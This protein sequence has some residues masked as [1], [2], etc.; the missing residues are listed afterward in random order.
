MQTR[1]SENTAG[2]QPELALR[3][4]MRRLRE[5]FAETGD[6][7]SRLDKVVRHV[8]GVMVAEVC[9]IYLKRQDGSLELFATEGL[10]PAS[11]HT[12]RLKRGEG[13]VGRC[14]ELGVPINE[15]DAQSHPAFSLRPETG[16]EVYH[17]LLAVPILRSGQVLGVLVVQ[18]HAYK[19]YSDDD[20][21]TL[22]STAM[23]VGEH[24]ATG[25]VARWGSDIEISRSLAAVVKGEPLSDGI[26]LGHVLLHEPRIV[27]TKLM[28]DDPAIELSRL[29]A[30]IAELRAAL[31]EMLGQEQLASD[32]D[33][34]DVL[35]AYRMFAHDRGWERRLREAV[36]SGLTAEAA[37]E[38]VQNS[39]RARMTRHAD[40]YWAERQR[41]F[42]DLS[43]RLQRILSG[44]GGNGRDVP[45]EMPSDTILVARTMGP[46]EL[47][48]YD[49]ARLRGL[50]IEDSSPQSHVAIV[51]KAL[52][53]PAVGRAV[54]IVDHVSPGD[55]IIIDAETG[56]VHLRPLQDVVSA[57]S[58]KV[59]FRARRQKKYGALRDKK[60]ITRDG[61]RIEVNINAGLL[62]DLSH[63][64]ESGADGIGLFR[65]ELQFMV[66]HTFPR[67]ERQAE[68]YRQVVEA[69]AGRP[70]VFRALDI[71]GDKVLPYLRSVKEEN[72]A[73]GWR[74]IRM[75]LDRPALFRTQVR[76]LLK[77][78][79]GGELRLMVP[80]IS[81][82]A[83][84]VTVK[85][86]FDRELGLIRRK[87]LPSP[88][89][90]KLGAMFE[91]PSLLFELDALL[92]SVDFLSI[93]SN[94]LLQFMFAAD[95]TN[96]RVASRYD[97]LSVAP[98]RALKSVADACRGHG[99]PLTICGEMAG[100]P[101]EAM[102]LIA[103]GFRSVSMAPSSVGPI[104]AMILSLD[105][106]KAADEMDAMLAR[107]EKDVRGALTRF[108]RRTGVE[109]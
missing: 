19:Q 15:P 71:G 89:R 70:I 9:S 104:K 103:L 52:G 40:A 28:S 16:E 78:T 67:L 4:I 72:P 84:M 22:S 51:A 50:V 17:S 98:L 106:G 8:A 61:R 1:R 58:D 55:G 63:L 108:A 47:L 90:V 23:V 77:A 109:L 53:I 100:R 96:A 105:A 18:N 56:E 102:A 91:V 107:G 73:I 75:S 65:T 3:T 93:G 29:E 74:A 36:Q 92:K 82:A 66:S 80:M 37:V 59:R 20:V 11:V 97:P 43:D 57:Y 34:R 38:R 14:A 81:T 12:T 5:I 39:S 13:L 10:N 54:G 101:L 41:D 24:L 99:V 64:D 46:A 69:A 6:G 87:G 60:A 88:E 44:R 2:S 26:A 45:A 21:E 48:D 79:A 35:E 62:Y 33:H 86:L 83:E 95:R 85:A 25:D 42:D 31:D 27:V 32:G 30:A 68:S 94:D 7:Q 49:P 76:A